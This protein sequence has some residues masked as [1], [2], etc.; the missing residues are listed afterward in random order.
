M[1][2]RTSTS[3]HALARLD[4]VDLAGKLACLA[5][6]R[7]LTMAAC[8]SSSPLE[9]DAR[10]FGRGAMACAFHLGVLD[11]TKVREARRP[12]S[13]SSTGPLGPS[14]SSASC[15]VRRYTAR[16]GVRSVLS[17][18]EHAGHARLSFIV[19]CMGCPAALRSTL[20][21]VGQR[22]SVHMVDYSA[23]GGPGNRVRASSGITVVS[24]PGRRRY[25]AAGRTT[26]ARR[27]DDDAILC[28][29]SPAWRAARLRERMLAVAGKRLHCPR[30]RRER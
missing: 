17:S 29:L 14:L 6:G 24:V 30:F 23:P 10:I 20:N 11:A 12:D 1:I 9:P 5:L 3:N 26:A 22:R 15:P 18:P 27:R 25:H 7:V 4:D 19:P 16:S 28:S 2:A 13:R 8:A 21:A